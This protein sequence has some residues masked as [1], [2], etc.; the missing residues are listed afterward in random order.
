METGNGTLYQCAE[1]GL[2][3][4]D[5]TTANQC[6]AWCKEYKSCNLEITKSAIERQGKGL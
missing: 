4:H 5:E 6:E 3:Y 1:C 2:H